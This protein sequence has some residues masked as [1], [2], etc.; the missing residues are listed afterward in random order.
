MS[1]FA[2][3]RAL[4]CALLIGASGTA[5]AQMSGDSLATLSTALVAWS[6]SDFDSHGPRPEQV[7]NVH[8]RYADR[9]DGGR[10]YMLCGEFLPARRTKPD[11]VRFATIR[12]DPYEQWIGGQAE[13]LC[14]RALP[15]PGRVGD[16]SSALDARLKSNAEST[17]RP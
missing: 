14:D 2:V 10:I 13:A 17:G 12:T 15:L 4:A 6:A 8:L 7:R 3:A 9:D 5:H 1:A 11:W 16:M